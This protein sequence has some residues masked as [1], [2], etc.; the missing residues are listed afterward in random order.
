MRYLVGISKP[1]NLPPLSF[2]PPDYQYPWASIYNVAADVVGGDVEPV[3]NEFRLKGVY[4]SGLPLPS[5]GGDQLA[6]SSS[7]HFVK[8]VILRAAYFSALVDSEFSNTELANTEVPNPSSS[9][10]MHMIV[11]VDS[12][13]EGMDKHLNQYEAVHHLISD[14]SMRFRRRLPSSPTADFLPI[15]PEVINGEILTFKDLEIALPAGAKVRFQ[16]VI[17]TSLGGWGANPVSSI[18][19]GLTV[20]WDEETIDD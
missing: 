9:D 3:Q 4:N 1:G 13:A 16:L 2:M 11:S 20:I 18:I 15:H 8:P 19:P 17:P 12:D 10:A 6:W 7:I 5:A 14:D